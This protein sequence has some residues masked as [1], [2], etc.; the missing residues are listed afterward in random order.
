MS[1][2]SPMA[3]AKITPG[4]VP[5]Q[6]SLPGNIVVRVSSYTFC[7]SD[8]LRIDR[9]PWT[10]APYSTLLFTD[11]FGQLHFTLYTC[12]LAHICDARASPPA[13]TKLSQLKLPVE[14]SALLPPAQVKLPS[15]LTGVP[16]RSSDPEIAAIQ[17]E[18]ADLNKKLQTGEFDIPPEH[19]R[20]PSPEPIYDRCGAFGRSA[21]ATALFC[22][23]FRA[24]C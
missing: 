8:L 21:P 2:R 11:G 7:A 4:G 17:E 3:L 15:A 20:S 22:G 14:D 18:L 23:C 9:L 5:S 19:E 12:R 24:N 6:I 16:D 1:P 10:Y 13:I